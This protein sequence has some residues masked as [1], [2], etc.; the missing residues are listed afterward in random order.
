MVWSCLDVFMQP[1]PCLGD[2]FH[3]ILPEIE[4]SSPQ[5][6][7][8]AHGEEFGEGRRG[9]FCPSVDSFLVLVEPLLRLPREGEGK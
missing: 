6:I 3:G 8:F 1:F 4:N 7:G 9:T 5:C 2:R